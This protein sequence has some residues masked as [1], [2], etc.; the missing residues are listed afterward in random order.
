M[1]LE[2]DKFHVWAA[3]WLGA[4]GRLRCTHFPFAVRT[5]SSQ[6]IIK[7]PQTRSDD[8]IKRKLINYIVTPWFQW[9]TSLKLLQH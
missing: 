1:C 4:L 6:R 5:T 9:N 3:W 2:F 8:F 7:S